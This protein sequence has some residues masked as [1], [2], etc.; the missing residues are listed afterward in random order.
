MNQTDRITQV[1]KLIHQLPTECELNL[2][3]QDKPSLSNFSNFEVNFV[4]SSSLVDSFE[5]QRHLDILL[6][7]NKALQQKEFSL[8]LPAKELLRRTS[9]VLEKPTNQEGEGKKSLFKGIS[10]SFEIDH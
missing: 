10:L 1:L 6:D 2:N 7:N 3:P 4:L 5:K 9:S 8:D